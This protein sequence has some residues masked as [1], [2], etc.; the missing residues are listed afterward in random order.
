[1]PSQDTEDLKKN[2]VP[3]DRTLPTFSLIGI[4]FAVFTWGLSFPLLKIALE[5]VPPITLAVLRGVIGTIPLIVFMILKWGWKG[6][7]KPLKEDFWFFL[8][9]GVVGITLPNIFQNYGMRM[10]S[11]HLSSIIQSSGPIFTIILAVL[12]LKEPLGINKI[13]GS[14]IAIMGTILLVTGGGLDLTDSTLIGNFL[15]LMSAIS[16]SISSIM[17]KRILERYE[18]LKVAT[19]SMFLGTLILALFLV[20]ESP[21]K[22]VPSI[23]LEYWLIIIVLA[24]L[25]GSL[26]LL[27]WYKILKDTEVSQLILFIYLIPVFATAIAYFWPGEIISPYTIFFAFLIVCGVMIAQHDKMSKSEK[28]R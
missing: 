14:A 11:A 22:D 17:S 1:M 12:L 24:L 21:T 20:F 19:L 16:Y 9:L 23:S 6:F 3:P 26:A 7:S 25:P 2:Q 8:S 4:L 18:P 13:L 15:V 5:A 10:T 27:I 28:I